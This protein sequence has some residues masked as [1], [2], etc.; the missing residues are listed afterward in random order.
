MRSDGR[1]QSVSWR[2]LL[3]AVGALA[4]VASAC[5][6]TAAPSPAP[7]GSVAPSLAAS[8]KPSVAATPKPAPDKVTFLTDFLL[9]G[10]HA[11]LYAAKAEG[12]FQEQ[13]IDVTIQAG[14]GS[15]DTGT[16]L[17]AGAAQFALID[18]STALLG[19]GKGQDIKLIGVHLQKHPGGLLYIKERTTI[20]TWKDI[21]GKKVGS[22]TGDAYLVA[23]PGLM[24]QNGADPTKFKEVDMA[25]PATTGALISGQV[26]AIPGSP[27][28]APPRADAAKQQGLTLQRFSFADNGYKA[29]G[30]AVAVNGKVLKDKPDLVQRFVNAWAKATVWSLANSDKAVGDFLAANADKNKDQESRSFN[31]SVPLIKGDGKLFT[32]DPQRLQINVDFVKDQYK[33]TVN[34]ADVYTNEFVQKLPPS[35]LQGKLP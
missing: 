24:R 20:N 33:S 16:Q 2:S 23:L 35:Y 19:I 4:I 22:A 18:V 5:G 31:E 12:F 8:V 29:I 7:A 11:P 26:D 32:F 21:E 27:M 17:S 6:G 14:K 28:T 30:F 34:A 15:V 3:V 13:N 1:S 25:G 9:W 10:W